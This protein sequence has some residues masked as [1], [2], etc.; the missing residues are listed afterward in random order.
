VQVSKDLG[1][2]HW[3]DDRG[4][5][6]EAAATVWAVFDIDIEYPFHQ[7]RSSVG[8][9]SGDAIC[10]IASIAEAGHHES[11]DSCLVS[12]VIARFTMLVAY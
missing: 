7:V 12:T 8:G 9:I 11:G 3:I 1:N 10:A 2:H 4:D 5:D 6:L